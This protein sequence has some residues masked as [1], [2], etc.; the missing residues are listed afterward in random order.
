MIIDEERKK[1]D[2]NP[3]K[4]I[5]GSEL[6]VN[7][8]EEYADAKK[9]VAFLEEILTEF[10]ELIK[11]SFTPHEIRE[12]FD[13]DLRLGALGH[14]LTEEQHNIFIEKEVV[15]HS[16]DTEIDDTLIFGEMMKYFN[17]FPS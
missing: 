6:K 13:S 11:D 2:Y 1:S 15:E 3:I 14:I 16:L 9:K 4:I 8:D 12:Y 10:A 7:L 17:C 5:S